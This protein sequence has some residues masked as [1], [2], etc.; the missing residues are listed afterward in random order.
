MRRFTAASRMLLWKF[1]KTAYLGRSGH[2]MVLGTLFPLLL[3]FCD[4]LGRAYLV[5]LLPGERRFDGLSGLDA[6]SAHQLSRQ[7]GKGSTQ[8]ILCGFVQLH[9]VA[10]CLLKAFTADGIETRGVLSHRAIKNGSLLLG[11]IQ[12]YHNRSFHAE[13]I[14]YIPRFVNRQRLTPAQLQERKTCFL[15]IAE[16]MGIRRSHVMKLCVPFLKW[17]A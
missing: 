10:G 6:S 12:L 9:P 13:S 16:A 1:P 2:F 15:P 7:I 14:S 5:F 8:G 4:Q 11:G 3:R 17:T